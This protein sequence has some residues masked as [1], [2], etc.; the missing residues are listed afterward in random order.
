MQKKNIQPIRLWFKSVQ[1][2]NANGE[3]VHLGERATFF[4][5]TGSAIIEKWGPNGTT[6]ETVQIPETIC[7]KRAVILSLKEQGY[8]VPASALQEAESDIQ[9]E[10]NASMSDETFDKAASKPTVQS[11]AAQHNGQKFVINEGALLLGRDAEACQIV[12]RDGTQGISRTHCAITWDAE[13]RV[14]IL[15]D[16]DSSYGT[17]LEDGTKLEPRKPYQLKPGDRFYLAERENMIL[18]GSDDAGQKPTKKENSERREKWRNAIGT[19]LK[20]IGWILIVLQVIGIWGASQ[21]GGR[22]FSFSLFS[23]AG[24]T[25]RVG[26]YSFAI[27]GIV[28]IRVGKRIKEARGWSRDRRRSERRKKQSERQ[29]SE[30]KRQKKR[31][32]L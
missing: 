7:S 24:L 31:R 20:T 30:K 10:R 27:V 32:N 14:F 5:D 18:L 17:F 13:Q 21:R 12:Y 19:L 28:L 15:M 9:I 1:G 16:L 8:D 4:P 11:L 25:E 22:Y 2:Y 3:R 26:Y 23:L 29:K 6:S